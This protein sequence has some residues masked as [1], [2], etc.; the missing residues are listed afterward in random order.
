M[1]AGPFSVKVGRGKVTA[2]AYPTKASSAKALGTFLFAHGAGAGQRHPYITGTAERLRTRGL[3]VVTF[4]FPYT[5]S[6][7]KLPDKNDALEECFGAVFAA[8]KAKIV[9]SKQSSSPLLVTGGK[10]MGGRIASQ[11]AAEGAI[12]PAALI[13]LGYP[14]HPPGKPTQRRDK[15]LPDVRAPMLFVQGTRDPFGTPAEIRR[16]LPN[17]AKGSRVHTVEGGDH[18]H[19]VPKRGDVAPDAVLATI[20]DAIVDWVN[21]L[22][23]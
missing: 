8:V 9:S 11:V 13:F 6:G 14:L 5:E 17:L 3:S 19:G 10:S 23:L 18:S 2:I 20:A 16:L 15:H 7:K 22:S 1:K 4:D 21:H 12:D